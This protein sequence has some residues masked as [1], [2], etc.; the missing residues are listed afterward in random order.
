MKLKNFNKDSWLAKC[1]QADKEAS[2]GCGLSD[3]LYQQ[4]YNQLLDK[5]IK[6]L[7]DRHIKKAIKIAK[8]QGY[9]T[10]EEEQN[11]HDIFFDSDCCVHGLDRDCCPAGCGEY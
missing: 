5:A 11:E 10:I 1:E 3:V 2:K 4:R 9:Q 7:P 8:E 6:A